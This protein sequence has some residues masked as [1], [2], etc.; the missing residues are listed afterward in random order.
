MDNN[1]VNPSTRAQ[2]AQEAMAAAIDE[3]KKRVEDLELRTAEI[4]R[5]VTLMPG[6]NPT[7]R[8]P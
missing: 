2:E 7:E 5:S 8:A 1:S 6:G 4:E 3:L